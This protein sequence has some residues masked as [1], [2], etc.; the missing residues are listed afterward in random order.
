[1]IC[2]DDVG[3]LKFDKQDQQQTFGAALETQRGLT[4]GSTGDPSLSPALS[5]S[6]SDINRL[7]RVP[8]RLAL[9]K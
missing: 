8:A 6:L 2:R 5:N 9:E 7:E 3:K 1:M 4:A